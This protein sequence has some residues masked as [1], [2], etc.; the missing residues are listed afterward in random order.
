MRRKYMTAMSAVAAS[1]LILAACGSDDDNGNGGDG[2]RVVNI[3]NGT[4]GDQGFFDDA[5]R[6][7]QMIED[8]GAEIR[9]V[10]AAVDNPAQ[11]RSNLESV[12][13][14]EWDI[15]VTGTS[16]M[17]EI[18]DQ[19]A[20]QY[21]DQNYIY[22]DDVVNQ[23]N[24]ASIVYKQNE[25]SYL[26]G[27]L[28]ALVTTNSDDF[29]LAT[30]SGTV[31]VVGGMDIPVI[32]DFV[33]GFRAGVEAVDPSIE[34]LVSFVGDFADSNRGHDLAT[35]MYNQGADVV[36]QVAGGAGLG[37]LTAAQD[38]ERY[39]IGVDSNQNPN[40]SGYILASMLKNIGI[41]IDTAVAAAQDGTLEFGVVTEY[42]LANN[43]V[44]LTYE[45]NGDIVPQEYQD[46]VAEYAELVISGE[47]EVPTTL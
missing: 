11:W 33:A 27:V 29:E 8:R 13:T 21:P 2:Y 18:L 44:S 3:I 12:S 42:G 46:Q 41:S 30:G 43:G 32:Q 34:V 6:G 9:N 4:L 47:L 35:A 31:G 23:P 17:Q 7:M 25:G 28:A 24:V 15:V 36:F 19:T 37:V 38:A 20:A 16:Q 1:V 39:A 26:A 22:Y 45:D 14:G 10:E 5:G 40:H